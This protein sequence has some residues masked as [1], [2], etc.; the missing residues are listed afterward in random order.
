MS[1]LGSLS[2]S[3][4]LS[5]GRCGLRGSLIALLHCLNDLE[6]LAHD[7]GSNRSVR[8]LTGARLA[9]RETPCQKALKRGL[10]ARIGEVSS[11]KVAYTK[12]GTL[13]TVEVSFTPGMV[14]PQQ[15]DRIV[16]PFNPDES[17]AWWRSSP[18]LL[19][20][21]SKSFSLVSSPGF[22]CHGM[23]Q[24]VQVH[25]AARPITSPSIYRTGCSYRM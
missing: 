15:G 18:T 19:G 13:D 22:T 12:Q 23:S 7:S 25:P 14:L 20:T 24:G 9:L 5:C 6:F 17:Q 10:L 16:S 8:E 3:T 11:N 2:R 21:A 1:H 4:V